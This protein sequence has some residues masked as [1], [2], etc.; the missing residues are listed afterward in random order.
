MERSSLIT[1]SNGNGMAVEAPSL[2]DETP[3]LTG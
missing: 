2:N 1:K 3:S